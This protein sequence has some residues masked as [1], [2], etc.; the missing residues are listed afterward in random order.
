MTFCDFVTFCDLK[1]GVEN[2]IQYALCS[3]RVNRGLI[4][5]LVRKILVTELSGHNVN[6]QPFYYSTL[7]DYNQQIFQ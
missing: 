2:L 4:N 6:T 3:N 1:S 7:Y 5:Y